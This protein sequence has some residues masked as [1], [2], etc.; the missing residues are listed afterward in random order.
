M[1]LPV[2]L[3]NFHIISLETRSMLL[4]KLLTGVLDQRGDMDIYLSVET[5]H[6]S[7]CTCGYAHSS[8]GLVLLYCGPLKLSSLWLFK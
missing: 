3:K 8:A 4:Y 6:M 5:A 7:V 2:Y 1:Y